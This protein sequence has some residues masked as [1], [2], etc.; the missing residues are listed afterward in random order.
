M[1]VYVCVYAHTHTHCVDEVLG[2]EYRSR[3]ET[4]G[5]LEESTWTKPRHISICICAQI[6]M[7]MFILEG[8]MRSWPDCFFF[9]IYLLPKK[10][11][12]YM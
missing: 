1:W 8:G 11:T 2:C 10:N 12:H 7:C 5:G 4:P 3:N 9:N 6:N